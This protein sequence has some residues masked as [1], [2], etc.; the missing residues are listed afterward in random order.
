MKTNGI[1]ASNLTN[2]E[3]RARAADQF[4]EESRSTPT[5]VESHLVSGQQTTDGK[6][7]AETPGAKPSDGSTK[8]DGH[9]TDS[10]ESRYNIVA[11]DDL[12]IAKALMR[13]RKKG[14]A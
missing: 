8:L 1:P 4:D 7:P 3:G 11:G 5:L 2:C 14:P 6:R 13:K 12:N 9:K 10:M